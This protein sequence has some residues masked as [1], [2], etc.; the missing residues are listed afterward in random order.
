MK[1]IVRD[2]T[3]ETIVVDMVNSLGEKYHFEVEPGIDRKEADT[4]MT[5]PSD[6]P[7]VK[8]KKGARYVQLVMPIA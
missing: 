2:W 6:S 1:N 7:G 3:H 4:F 5:R 8:D